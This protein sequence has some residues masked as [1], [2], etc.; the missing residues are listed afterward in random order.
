MKRLSQSIRP[1]AI[2]VGACTALLMVPMLAMAQSTAQDVNVVNPASAPVNVKPVSGSSV[3]VGNTYTAPV[4]VSPVQRDPWAVTMQSQGGGSCATIPTP[5]NRRIVITNVSGW[6]FSPSEIKVVVTGIG[7]NSSLLSVP[8]EK[9]PGT[10]GDT[11]FAERW[12]TARETEIYLPTTVT[13][14]DGSSRALS[15]PRACLTNYGSSYVD[16]TVSGYYERTAGT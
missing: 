10:G 1:F 9:I 8:L 12:G 4:P 15:N 16:A 5:A 13:I 7:I 3:K 6:G 14:S 11:G 2:S